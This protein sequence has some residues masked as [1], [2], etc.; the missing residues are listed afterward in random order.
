MMNGF[1]L[2]VRMEVWRLSRRKKNKSFVAR[3][4]AAEIVV[5]IVMLHWTSAYAQRES[6]APTLAYQSGRCTVF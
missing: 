2:A 5:G 1:D 6:T 3:E 4:E